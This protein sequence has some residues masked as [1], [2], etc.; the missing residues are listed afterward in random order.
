M[1]F[2]CTIDYFISQAGILVYFFENKIVPTFPE[3][4]NT[5]EKHQGSKAAD[6]I[7]G[8]GSSIKDQPIMQILGKEIR[9]SSPP[10]KLMLDIFN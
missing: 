5:K 7:H 6:L 2:Q 1:V 8:A 10:L 3:K 4:P 9:A